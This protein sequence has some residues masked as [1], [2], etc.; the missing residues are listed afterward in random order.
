MFCPRVGE[1]L[2]YRIPLFTGTVDQSSKVAQDNMKGTVLRRILVVSIACY[3]E[4]NFHREIFYTKQ[5]SRN[6]N[7][8]R[9]SM[10]VWV[11][12]Y[13]YDIT[14][15]SIKLRKMKVPE[16]KKE[17]EAEKVCENCKAT[18]GS[19]TIFCKKFQENE[20]RNRIRAER[21]QKTESPKSIRVAKERKGRKNRRG[22][23]TYSASAR[24]SCG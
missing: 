20:H 18:A 3:H 8:Y 11:L 4:S 13:M 17:G 1:L 2:H 21:A 12:R 22:S 23:R 19:H 6:K 7:E 14:K 16:L 24:S 5:T 15:T 9:L 10:Q